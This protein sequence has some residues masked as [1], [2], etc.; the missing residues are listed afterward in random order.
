MKLGRTLLIFAAFILETKG[1]KTIQKRNMMSSSV[2]VKDC[3]NTVIKYK[4]LI[5]L[6]RT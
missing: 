5:A 3:R 2:S 1:I 6:A 4:E